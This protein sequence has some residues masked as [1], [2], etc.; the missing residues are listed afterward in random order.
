M[1][2]NASV[3]RIHGALLGWALLPGA[4]LVPGPHLPSFFIVCQEWHTRLLTVT[5]LRTLITTALVLVGLPSW[6]PGF[7]SSS[8]PPSCP[9]FSH[10]DTWGSPAPPT[11]APQSFLGHSGCGYT[12]FR[13]QDCSFLPAMSRGPLSLLLN[14]LPCT[15]RH[16][17]TPLAILLQEESKATNS[18]PLCLLPVSAIGKIGTLAPTTTMVIE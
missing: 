9:T 2:K 7:S 16:T 14:V 3:T 12:G 5:P 18:C 15:V 6:T 17:L 1:A 11:S 4:D 13:R 8:C 10:Q